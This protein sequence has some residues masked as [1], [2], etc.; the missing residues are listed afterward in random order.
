VASGLT[1]QSHL[2][3][4]TK[5]VAVHKTFK[6]IIPPLGCLGEEPFGGLMSL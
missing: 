6:F 2:F 3:H 1:P 5:D 4:P